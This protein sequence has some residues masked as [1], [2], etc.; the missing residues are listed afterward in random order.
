[1][2]Y[3]YFY[4]ITNNINNHFYYGVHCTNNLNDNYM[5]SGKRLQ[6]AIKKYGLENFS[7]EI[8]K[9]FNSK[10]E[11][12]E[13]EEQIVNENLINNPNCYN[14][15]NGGHG[16]WSHN[17]G[18]VTVK[19]KF[20]NIF[21]VN[22]NDQRYISGELV[23]INK[24][25]TTVKDKNGNCFRI[26]IDDPR[27]ISGELVSVNKN[28][29]KKKSSVEKMRNSLKEYYKTH[30]AHTL[31]GKD[32]PCY[33][34]T[35]ITKDK[36]SIRIK[37]ED[38]QKYL[39]NGWEHKRICGN[40]KGKIYIHRFLENNTF[41]N[42]AINRNELDEYIKNGWIK[43]QYKPNA[44]LTFKRKYICKLIDN[45]LVLKIINIKDSEK[46]IQDGWTSGKKLQ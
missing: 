36:I 8:L 43:G 44:K 22:K 32:H 16:S 34:T 21:D 5:G 39:D 10:E 1:M 11:A 7:K 40:Y 29:P 31:Y 41:E 14:L 25:T 4:K 24:G 9:Y 37:N 33:G 23:S 35:Y 42:K 18:K 6:Y 3:F 20:G 27:Y 38:L 28:V 17:K 26:K 13:Y 30:K 19:D 15:T 12:F 45:K 46:Y 2:K